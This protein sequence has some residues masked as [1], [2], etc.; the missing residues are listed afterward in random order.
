MFESLQEPEKGLVK[1]VIAVEGDTIE[2]RDKKVVLNDKILEEPYVQ[3]LNPHDIFKGDN[4]APILIPKGYVFVMGDNRDVSNDSR[5][6]KAPDGTWAPY[7]PLSVVK[8]LV[9]CP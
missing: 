2:L 4:S 1:R 7:V 6:W 8:G 9:I 3:L 5:D